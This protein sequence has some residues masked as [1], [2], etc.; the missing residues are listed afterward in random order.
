MHFQRKVLMTEMPPLDE[1]KIAKKN[2]G[3]LMRNQLT[4]GRTRSDESR[5]TGR[6]G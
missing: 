1:L 4:G 5:V 3:R 6:V 2:F